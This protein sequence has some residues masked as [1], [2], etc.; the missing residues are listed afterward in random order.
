M[1]GSS[2][3]GT[4]ED[5][6]LGSPT[7][8]GRRRSSSMDL[9]DP[10]GAGGQGGDVQATIPPCMYIIG[11]ILEDGLGLPSWWKEDEAEDEEED[12]EEE[13][14]EDGNNEENSHEEFNDE[15]YGSEYD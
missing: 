10:H 9:R 6:V 4:G 8:V 15:D 13:P 3:G 14:I 7:P 2:T 5:G 1:G 12:A 11:S